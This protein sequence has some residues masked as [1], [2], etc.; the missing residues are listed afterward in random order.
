[1]NRNRCSIPRNFNEPYITLGFTNPHRRYFTEAGEE[2]RRQSAQRLRRIRV[3]FCETRLWNGWASD[4]NIYRV[5]KVDLIVPLRITRLLLRERR[6]V[7][8]SH[9]VACDVGARDGLGR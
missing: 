7:G 6:V 3:I 2:L 9:R 5:Q 8:K 1:M 4:V